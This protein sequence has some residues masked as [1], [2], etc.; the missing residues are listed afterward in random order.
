M[1]PS[2]RWLRKG[3][4]DERVNG[5]R[6]PSRVL[7]DMPKFQVLMKVEVNTKCFTDVLLVKDLL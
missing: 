7:S 5:R 1:V 6:N 2:I 4:G 3:G